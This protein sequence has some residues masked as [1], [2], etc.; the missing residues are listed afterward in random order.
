M[1]LKEFKRREIERNEQLI[2]ALYSQELLPG[3]EEGSIHTDGVRLLIMRQKLERDQDYLA[4]METYDSP[5][6]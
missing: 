4:L 2:K 5:A 3:Q 1:N 6:I